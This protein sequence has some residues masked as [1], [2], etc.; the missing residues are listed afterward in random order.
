MSASGTQKGSSPESV[1][2]FKCLCLLEIG[3]CDGVGCDSEGGWGLGCHGE[4]REGV[5]WDVMGV[6]MECSNLS[7]SFVKCLC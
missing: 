3:Y 1:S 4:R 5:A 2:I 7:S 6:A